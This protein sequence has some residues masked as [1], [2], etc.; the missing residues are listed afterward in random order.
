MYTLW[1]THLS[2]Q[3]DKDKFKKQIRSAKDV[4]DRQK[5]ILSEELK[6]LER[7]EVGLKTYETPSW[8]AKQ[9]HMNGDRS[10]IMWL[11]NLIDL[12]QQKDSK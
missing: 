9:A 7:V 5:D 4:L 1:T 12:D 11:L 2:D 3:E 6:A 8:S 10:R